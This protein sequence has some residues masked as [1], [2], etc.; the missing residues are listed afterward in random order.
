MGTHQPGKLAAVSLNKLADGWHGD[1]GSLYLFVRGASKAWVFRYRGQDG[2][3]KHMG[4]GS[5]RSVSLARARELAR[6]LRSRLKDPAN[7]VDPLQARRDDE[8]A[9]QV[10]AAKSITFAAAA[11]A[12]I[13]AHKSSWSNPKHVQQWVNTL[14]TYAGPIFGALPVNAVDTALVMRCLEPLWQTKQETASRLRGRI[15][16]VLDWATVRGSRSGDNPARWRGHL[17]K[18][19]APRKKNQKHHAALDFKQLP[20]FMTDL[21]KRDGFAARALEFAILTA[22]RSGEVRGATWSEIDFEEKLWIVPG[23]RMKAG[24]EHRVPLSDAAM[25][26]LT[27]MPR[28][29]DAPDSLIF[30]SPIGGK[31]SDMALGAVLTRMEVAVTAHGFRSTFRDWS[32]ERTSHQSEVIEMALA[33]TIRN[34][35]EAA[36]RRGDL[37]EKRRQLMDDWA[38]FCDHLIR[39]TVISFKGKDVTNG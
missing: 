21:R 7:P 25:A 15:E 10:E 18:L 12:Y 28:Q 34:Q 8:K 4:L 13:E 31:L 35:V 24:K 6:E 32:A 39:G 20:A 17:D 9:R 3:R 27:A 26:I 1:G 36:Y 16:A 38:N 22:A 11:E 29:E 37:L 30:T 33:H 2:R 19:L 5:I 23:S 14:T